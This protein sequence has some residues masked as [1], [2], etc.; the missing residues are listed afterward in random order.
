[1]IKCKKHGLCG[2]A[3]NIENSIIDN[4]NNN[5]EISPL[6]IC[7]IK[8]YL[9]DDNEYLYYINYIITNKSKKQ[10]KISSSYKIHN[11]KEELKLKD[12]DNL[13]GVICNECLINYNY[14]KNIKS[15]IKEYQNR[16]IDMQD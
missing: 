4:I 16:D 12:L 11:E 5:Q 2:L 8:V 10:Y 3:I 7:V 9:Y 1:M 14:L 13:V 6:D 15:I